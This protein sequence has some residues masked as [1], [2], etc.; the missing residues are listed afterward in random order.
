MRMTPSTPLA[1]HSQTRG[2]GG[3]RKTGH[4]R[5]ATQIGKTLVIVSTSETGSLVNAKKVHT[6]LKL[7]ARLRSH[8]VPGPKKT[9]GAPA[10]RAS[11]AENKRAKA[12]RTRAMTCQAQEEPRTCVAQPR[13]AN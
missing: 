2:D 12:A 10:E 13:T 9:R 1:T 8:S 6:R 7:P 3:S 4:E 11:V 5:I